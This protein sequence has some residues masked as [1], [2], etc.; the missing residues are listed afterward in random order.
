MSRI[1]GLLTAS[2]TALSLLL[3]QHAAAYTLK[4]GIT[5]NPASLSPAKI[6]G[7]TW[8]EDV[9]RDIYAGLVDVSADGKVVP[10][11]AERWEESEDGLTWT[12]HL[13]D[14]KWS[15]GSPV[16]ADDFLFSLRY[17]VT[18]QNAAT[19]VERLYPI[20]NAED[21]A[22]GKAAPDTLGVESKDDGHTLVIHLRERT[23]YFAK[24][25]VLYPFYPM[26][27]TLVEKLGDRWSQLDSIVTNGAFKPTEWTINTQL[28]TVKNPNYYDA[29][30]VSLEGVNFYPM[31]D[32]N[33][34]ITR[35]RAGGLDVLRDFPA[36]RLNELKGVMGNT[37]H[38]SPRL[39]TY[40]YT[41]N[42]RSG[43][44]TADP[45]V[46]EALSLA[47]QRDLITSKLL[48]HSVLPAYALVPPGVSDYTNQPL[49][50]LKGD[51]Q[52]RI[53]RAKALLAE[54]GY[55]ASKPLT[56]SLSYNNSPEHKR[57][58]VAV[59]AMWKQIG[60]N[61]SLES[62]E[63]NVHY[64]NLRHGQFQ[65]GRAAWLSSYDDAQNFLQL[66]Y[67]DGNNY[68]N[69]QNPHYRELYDAANRAKTPQERREL[70]QEAERQLTN[71]IALIPIYYYAALNLVN[72]ALKGWQDNAV[73]IHP[74]RWISHP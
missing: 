6:T 58:A 53:A 15:D 74:S 34:G 55:S 26:P 39:G 18:P 21:I 22:H 32:R 50:A 44:P 56:L 3:G 66:T 17:F 4:V 71:D 12:F 35:L 28:T 73:D 65:V 72:P 24:M 31:E 9:L 59:A 11:V 33:A 23:P 43:Q 25:L 8:E 54:A 67:A 69:Y 70:M 62:A 38:V 47:I 49:A 7:G 68:G 61:T 48:D 45:R 16:T 14:S 13:R 37:V 40:Y 30:H 51:P 64:A 57:I 42:L 63:A 19:G 2:A 27:H 5:S 20:V 60:V 29:A 1:H 41:V 10:G 52:K 36:S 46:R